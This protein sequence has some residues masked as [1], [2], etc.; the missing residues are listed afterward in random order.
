MDS[1]FA[2][3]TFALCAS[4]DGAPRNDERQPF[5]FNDANNS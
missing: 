4:V 1:G 2:L 3:S 5:A